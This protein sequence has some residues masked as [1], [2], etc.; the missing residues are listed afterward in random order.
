MAFTFAYD[1][2]GDGTSVGKDFPL[3]TAGNYGTGGVKKG[4]LV[5][6]SSGLLRK[7]Q[8]A[9]AT[10][11]ALGVLEGQEFLGLTQG[12][13]YAAA[14]ASF[15]ANAINTTKN[16][17]GVGKVRNNKATSVF[18]VPVRQAGAVQT[19]TNTHLGSNYNIILDANNDQQVDLNLQTAA[20]VK[21]V[22]YTPDG[23]Y[24]FVTLV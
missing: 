3:D 4:D 7:A 15:I 9:T 19:A 12:S 14:N 1:L 8:A 24:V 2:T 10:G 21:I 13:P 6:L 16:P 11:T 23:K 20:H 18:K 5:F 17:N 22:D